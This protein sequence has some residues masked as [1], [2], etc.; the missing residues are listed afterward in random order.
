[1]MA[2]CGARLRPGV[3]VVMEA[4][5]LS[6]RI[7]AA[8]LVITG[9]GSFDEQSLHGKTAS[10][11]LTACE[12]AR[13]PAVLVCGRAEID[14]GPIPLRSLVDRVGVEAALADAGSA[15]VLVAEDL[16]RDADQLVGARP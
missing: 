8:D 3:E 1:L 11:V 4:L 5:G 9:E 6:A 16:A 12:L 7:A 13:V 2:F 10:G 15:V 14:P